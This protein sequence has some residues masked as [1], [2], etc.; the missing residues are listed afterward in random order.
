[1]YGPIEDGRCS[2][3]A[4]GNQRTMHNAEC[5]SCGRW[6]VVSFSC[7]P[8]V[9]IISDFFTSDPL[10]LWTD[11]WGQ[12]SL[13]H[14]LVSVRN[15]SW[16]WVAAWARRLRRLRLLEPWFPN[17]KLSRIPIAC[18]HVLTVTG[19]SAIHNQ[20]TQTSISKPK[21]TFSLHDHLLFINGESSTDRVVAKPVDT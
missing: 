10:S 21:V 11:F 14:C 6:C 4:I 16:Y 17:L 3:L 18:F 8:P 19:R 7:L 5:R 15:P 12:V 2:R 1:M 13:F 20:E 9:H